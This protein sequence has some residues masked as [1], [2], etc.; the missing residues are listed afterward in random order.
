MTERTDLPISG[1]KLQ[2]GRVFG[3][4]D[5][6]IGVLLNLLHFLLGLDALIFGKGAV[7]TLLLIGISHRTYPIPSIKYIPVE[8][9]PKS[10]V[11]QAQYFAVL[12]PKAKREP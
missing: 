11:P 9:G 10:A 3:L 1:V 5:L 4:G 6:I 7:V 8:H 12:R 2:Q